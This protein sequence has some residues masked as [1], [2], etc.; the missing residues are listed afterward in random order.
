M[1]PKKLL[2]RLVKK[3]FLEPCC[4]LVVI[5]YPIFWEFYVLNISDHC[6]EHRPLM[7]LTTLQ[8]RHRD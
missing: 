2:G 8:G 5:K 4:V 6:Y 1:K 3:R 7:G